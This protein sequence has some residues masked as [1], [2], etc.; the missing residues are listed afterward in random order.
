MGENL[1]MLSSFKFRTEREA[2]AG[3]Q[4]L[5]ISTKSLSE[6][7]FETKRRFSFL[8]TLPDADYPD[9]WVVVE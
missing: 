4:T 9:A 3:E 1:E 5:R 2:P 7:E 6:L 8:D